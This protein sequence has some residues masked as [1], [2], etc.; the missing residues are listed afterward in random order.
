MSYILLTG[1][2]LF[3]FFNKKNKKN[4][5]S[6]SSSSTSYHHHHHQHLFFFLSRFCHAFFKSETFCFATALFLHFLFSFCES[7]LD[8]SFAFSSTLSIL[9]ISYH[10]LQPCRKIESLIISWLSMVA[11]EKEKF[12]CKLYFFLF[13]I[14]NDEALVTCCH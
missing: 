9:F 5:F 11:R 2:E 8:E 4:Y 10:Q 7:L 6:F 14:V 1:V 13:L 3:F 12:S